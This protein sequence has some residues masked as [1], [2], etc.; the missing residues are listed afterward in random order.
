MFWKRGKEVAPIVATS[1]GNTVIAYIDGKQFSKIVA[2]PEE[3]IELY[4]YLINVDVKNSVEV[5]D[6]IACMSIKKTEY[7]NR[8][9]EKIAEEVENQEK[10]NKVLE[11]MSS[12]ESDNFE[13]RETSFYIKGI[14]IS[15]PEF[16]V[17]EFYNRRGSEEDTNSL[18]A[19]WKLLSLNPDP[20][21][22]EDLYRFLIRNDMAVTPSGYFVAYRNVDIKKESTDDIADFITSSRIK[23]KG[24]KKSPKNYEV[25]LD[26]DEEPFLLNLKRANTDTP[27]EGLVLVGNLEAIYQLNKGD[28]RTSAVYTDNW[29]RSMTI[30]I[31]EAVSIPREECDADPDVSCSNGLHLGNKQFMSRNS[32]GKEG[33]ICL[34]N[35]MHVI[36]VPYADGKKLRCCEYFPIATAEY[37]NN[38]NIIPMDTNTF[39]YTIQEHTVEQIDKMIKAT[40]FESLKEHKVVPQELSRDALKYLQR[41]AT[42][43]LRTIE[44]MA[45]VTG[46]RMVGQTSLNLE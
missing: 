34:C 42:G 37:D 43:M 6:A 33:L 35:P 26:V 14:N 27:L 16:L 1:V 44:E 10:H 36:A 2:S 25:W 17:T 29:T 24:Q 15:V 13:I 46:S 12:L 28:T 11:W 31:G 20:R 18:L 30:N 19:F 45:E 40:R 4:K 23:V 3:G 9:E 39:E 22:R 21:C 5:D 32:F 8:E 38:G 7:E 41:E